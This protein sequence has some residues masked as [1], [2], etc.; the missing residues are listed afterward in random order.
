MKNRIGTLLAS[1]L[2][3]SGL[4]LVGC[5]SASVYQMDSGERTAG[6]EG[7][8]NV[9]RDKNGNH[10]VNLKVAHLPMPS[11]LEDGMATYVV[12]VAPA[13]GQTPY[14]VGQ[15]RL[16]DDRS[17]ELNFTTPFRSFNMM[18][19]AEV[20]GQVMSPSNQVVL[21]RSVGNR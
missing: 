1:M 7:E 14:N 11:R 9:D 12:W 18:V 8:L 13:E 3:V 16:R 10:V 17:G 20:D 6:A 19:T 15:I 21:R 5:S 2:L 4:A